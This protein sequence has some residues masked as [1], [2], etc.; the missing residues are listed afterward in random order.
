MTRFLLSIVLLSLIGCT[1][2]QK[3]QLEEP[4]P[5]PTHWRI[6]L[7]IIRVQST[8]FS[9]YVSELCYDN[10]EGLVWY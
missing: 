4:R 3:D 6:P 9:V 2:L 1:Q 8:P 7:G 5:A 10:E